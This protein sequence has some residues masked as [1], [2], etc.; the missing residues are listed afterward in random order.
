MFKFRGT[1]TPKVHG[2]AMDA[3]RRTA[4][5]LEGA[6]FGSFKDSSAGFSFFADGMGLQQVELTWDHRKK[7]LGGVYRSVLEVTVAT[8][9]S[10]FPKQTLHYLGTVLKGKPEFRDATKKQ[11]ASSA[12]IEML[13]TDKGVVDALAMQDI[14]DMTLEYIENEGVVHIRIV[15]LGGSFVW[16]LFPP[17]KYYVR[18]PEKHGEAMWKTVGCIARILG[19]DAHCPGEHAV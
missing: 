3:L 6:G 16:M 10:P 8:D 9:A 4:E 11:N 7:F 5:H 18:L 1:Y 19:R 14:E 2:A 17:M 13:N 15:P 12:L